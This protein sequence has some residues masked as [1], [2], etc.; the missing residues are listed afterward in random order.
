MTKMNND[1]PHEIASSPH[2]TA[3]GDDHPEPDVSPLAETDDVVAGEMQPHPYADMFPRMQGVDFSALVASIEEYGLEEPIVIYEGKI[4]DGRNRYAACI[5]AKVDPAFTEYED[6][7]PLG[8]VLIKNVLRRDLNASQRAMIAAK[9]ANLPQGGDHKSEDF[10]ASNDG[11]KIKD[12]AQT[13][14]VSPKTVERAK[15]VLA[16]GNGELITAVESGTKSVSAVA[17][18]ITGPSVPVETLPD[19]ER[20]SKKLLKL[21]KKTGEEGRALFLEAIGEDIQ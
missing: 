12:A 8:Y 2:L 6:D 16:S 3:D 18:Q 7:D 4:L 1:D 9:M 14:R 11:L 20:Q 15:I 21:W 5:K 13:L 19:G 17:K 10:K